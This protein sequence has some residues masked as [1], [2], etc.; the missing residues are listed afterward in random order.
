[1]GSG[2]EKSPWRWHIE[3]ILIQESE[4]KVEP[5]LLCVLDYSTKR[6]RRPQD[7]LVCFCVCVNEWCKNHCVGAL[8]LFLYLFWDLR[9][10][11]ARGGVLKSFNPQCRNKMV[12]VANVLTQL[13]RKVWPDKDIFLFPGNGSLSVYTRPVPVNSLLIAVNC[14]ISFF[15][16]LFKT[17][18][19]EEKLWNN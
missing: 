5:A 8:D 4:W 16:H 12:T 6:I 2:K 11:W 19:S 13:S 14:W 1:M 10:S 17:V 9:R 15:Q 3:E 18:G 7:K